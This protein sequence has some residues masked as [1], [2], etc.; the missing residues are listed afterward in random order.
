MNFLKARLR[1][2]STYAGIGVLIPSLLTA[3]ATRDWVSAVGV[4]GG[5]MA[6]LLPEPKVSQEKQG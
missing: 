3:I 1:E 4:F 5:I 6:V 2:P